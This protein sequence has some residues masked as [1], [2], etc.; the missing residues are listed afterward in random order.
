MLNHVEADG[1]WYCLL[2]RY[3]PCCVCRVTPRPESAM[4]SKMKFKDGPCDP[5]KHLQKEGRT[6]ETTS[7]AGRSVH[8]LESEAPSSSLAQGSGTS[9][10]R[11]EHPCKECQRK[12]RTKDFR[13]DAW[14]KIPNTERC[15]E[16]EFPDCHCCGFNKDSSKRAKD[17]LMSSFSC[18]RV[19]HLRRRW[20]LSQS[21][22]ALGCQSF[23]FLRELERG[24]VERKRNGSGASLSRLNTS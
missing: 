10:Q 13:L 19:L 5:C 20:H 16:C 24:S 9:R 6:K 18:L 1:S 23:C 7:D 14:G 2:H 21:A 4:A 12:R 22:R 3:P 8:T 15:K 17:L 11:G